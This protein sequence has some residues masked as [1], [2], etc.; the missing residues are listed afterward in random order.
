MRLTFSPLACWWERSFSSLS[1]T[2]LRNVCSKPWN[3]SG[4]KRLDRLNGSADI[5]FCRRQIGPFG[6]GNVGRPNPNNETRVGRQFPPNGFTPLTC[7]QTRADHVWKD[8]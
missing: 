7:C 1:A 8:I 4:R 2:V 6:N 5:L 3:F